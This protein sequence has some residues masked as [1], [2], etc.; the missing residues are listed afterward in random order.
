MNPRPWVG[1]LVSSTFTLVCAAQ[2]G[3]SGDASPADLSG[4]GASSG[5]GGAGA[6]AGGD[7]GGI[8][9][10]VT[11]FEASMGP[12]AVSSGEESTQCVFRRLGNTEGAY[13]RRFRATLTEASHHMIVYRSDETEEDLDPS[14][15]QGFSGLLQGEHP[16]FIAQQADATLTLPMD[17]DRPVGLRIE[18]NQ[19]LRMEMHFIN[20]AGGT[21]D[22]I[23][24]ATVDTVPLD[25]SI[26]E[27]DLAFWG[28]QDILVPPNS[29]ADTGIKFQQALGDTN[30]FAL[31]THQHHL[32]SRMRIWQTE[33]PDDL[34]SE[35]VADSTNWSDPPLELFD[36]P[37]HFPPGSG[38][39]S[40]V[41]FAYQ[42]EWQ[43]PSATTVGF[44]E[45]FD[46]E[47]CFLW[48]YYYPSQGFHI[49]FDGFFKTG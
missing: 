27:S 21:I 7:T 33:S 2:L 10:E 6:T 15:C 26:T 47:M 11:S 43:N 18:P 41:G 3:C 13:V 5:T 23:G 44:G 28:T 4:A 48:H 46:Q 34:S 36:P 32:G 25:T 42:C 45:D 16:I 29:A 31:T 20:A 49:C 40:N 14:P 19:M 12:I 35:P 17:G 8:G 24:T 22:A 30:T 9:G 38:V 39:F 1:R 37:L